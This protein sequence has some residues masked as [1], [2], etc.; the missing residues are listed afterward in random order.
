VDDIIDFG[1]VVAAW[2]LGHQIVVFQKNIL[3][4]CFEPP[5]ALGGSLPQ[6]K[7]AYQLYLD[8]N[9]FLSVRQPSGL[10]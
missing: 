6:R 3:P 4:A 1:G 10:N 9:R 8:G 7:A 5:P 2:C